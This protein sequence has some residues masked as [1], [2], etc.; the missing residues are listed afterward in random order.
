MKS[1]CG[2]FFSGIGA[3]TFIVAAA[4]ACVLPKKGAV[5]RLELA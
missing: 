3:R 2:V 4:T 1:F 5:V